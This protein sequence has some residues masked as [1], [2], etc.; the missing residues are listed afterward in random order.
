MFVAGTE[1]WLVTVI[2]NDTASPGYTRASSP[3]DNVFIKARSNIS[4][5]TFSGSESSSSPPSLSTVSS[6]AEST[7]PPASFVKSVSGVESISVG[8]AP[9]SS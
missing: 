9:N 1:P 2:S 6:V 7:T 5:N 4:T 8:L 3:A